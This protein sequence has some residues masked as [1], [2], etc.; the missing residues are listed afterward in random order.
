MKYR[1]RIKEIRK[2][3][4]EELRANPRNWRTHNAAQKT[5]LRGM[6]EEIGIWDV[7]IAYET[8]AG[9]QLLDGHLR[10]EDDPSTVWTVVV[11]DV[12]DAEAQKILVTHDPLSQMAG[13]DSEML[14]SLF[15]DLKEMDDQLATL[16]WP[17]YVMDPLL[18]ADW[19]PPAD[20][21]DDPFKPPKDDHHAVKFTA[22]QWAIIDAAHRKH[23]MPV[24]EFLTRLAESIEDE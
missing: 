15:K 12:N 1:D 16:V 9:L 8:E 21:G 5:A 7:L 11:L 19:K 4:A 14:A 18:A 17:D 2:V 13:Q 24:A 20:T 10:T 6:L 22:E 3:K 23:D